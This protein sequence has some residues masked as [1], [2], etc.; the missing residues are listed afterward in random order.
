MY[1]D[2]I[3]SLTH[4]DEW[5]WTGARRESVLSTWTPTVDWWVSGP[6]AIKQNNTATHPCST[7]FF[8]I[9]IIRPRVIMPKI[10]FEAENV[11][12][13]ELSRRSNSG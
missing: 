2:I 1:G 12:R 13:E 5:R 11:E 6:T 8:C 7:T 10:V 3:E 9:L 4:F